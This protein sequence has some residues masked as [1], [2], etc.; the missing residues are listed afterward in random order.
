MKKEKARACPFCG[1]RAIVQQEC[2]DKRYYTVRCRG[3]DCIVMPRT[4]FI[5]GRLKAIAIWNGGKIE[6]Q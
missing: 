5:R 1:A 6:K 3:R 4:T 2:L